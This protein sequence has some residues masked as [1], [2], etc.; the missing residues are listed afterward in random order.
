MGVTGQA[1]LADRLPPRRPPGR[2]VSVTTAACR[3]GGISP[4]AAAR[5]LKTG[6]AP[7]RVHVG[8]SSMVP[9][10]RPCRT[11]RTPCAGATDGVPHRVVVRAPG[12]A[13]ATASAT[14][15]GSS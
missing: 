7:Q 6:A 14:A 13:A 5:A 15:T 3:P 10:P 9:T 2:P 12:T 1:P 8:S 11:R 4:A